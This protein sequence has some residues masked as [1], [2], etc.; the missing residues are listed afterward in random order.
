MQDDFSARFGDATK[1]IMGKVPE[2]EGAKIMEMFRNV[3]K[4]S[5]DE[6][7]INH[8]FSRA[9]WNGD[10]GTVLVKVYSDKYSGE[11]TTVYSTTVEKKRDGMYQLRGHNAIDSKHSFRESKKYDEVNHDLIKEL[12]LKLID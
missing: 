4:D 10:D 7:N 6:N 1:E 12:V 5:L 9:R 2:E 3:I 11:F 8:M